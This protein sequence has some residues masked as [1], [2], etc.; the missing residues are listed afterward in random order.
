MKKHI[1]THSY[2]QAKFKCEECDFVGGSQMTI[3]VHLGRA[4]SEQFEFG[5]CEY[6][7]KIHLF[8]CETYICNNCDKRMNNL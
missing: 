8:T 6:K 2:R 3:E 4:H 1:K 5:I 7:A